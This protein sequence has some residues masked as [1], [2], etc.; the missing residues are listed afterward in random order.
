MVADRGD[1][2]RSHDAPTGLGGN[3]LVAICYK[4]AAPP[5]VPE[6]RRANCQRWGVVYA[7][8]AEDLPPPAPPGADATAGVRNTG[9]R[10]LDKD[11]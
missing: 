11:G 7:F 4:Q 5:E 3:I 9:R 10:R 1:G 2:R 6:S 8:D